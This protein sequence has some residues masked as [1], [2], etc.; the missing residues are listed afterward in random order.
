MNK[1]IYMAC[2]GA[3]SLA[4]FACSDAGKSVSGSSEDPNVITAKNESSSSER[5][6]ESSSSKNDLSSSSEAPESSSSEIPVESSSS[7]V[8]C[9]THGGGGCAPVPGGDLWD[10]YEDA[11]VINTSKYAEGV[12]SEEQMSGKDA[13]K[14]YWF[15][16]ATEGGKTVI[17]WPAA[18]A[19]ASSDS[20]LA[21]VIAE[22]E[23]IRGTLQFDK[24][25][26]TS[27]PYAVV[28][29]SIAGK[30]SAGNYMTADISNWEG[31]CVEYESTVSM[32]LRLDLG[33]SLNTEL[34][35]D[36]PA[37]PLARRSTFGEACFPWDKF[38]QS[39][40]SEKTISTEEAVKKVAGIWFQFEGMDG[41]TGD[42]I[43]YAVGSN[44]DEY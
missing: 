40:W 8:L 38:K 26:L 20:T 41:M 44:L 14:W 32:T 18:T 6:E 33:D 37:V 23:G 12:W 2:A 22:N 10:P 39:G 19:D 35:Y 42:F 21:V 15:T 43:I 27:M 5:I 34:N 1:K 7:H 24:G 30:D 11:D 13:G 29:F 16:D 36:T 31:F 4:M 9:K 25:D 3:L 17:E 28:G